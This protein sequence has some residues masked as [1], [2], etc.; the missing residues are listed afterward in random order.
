M[1]CKQVYLKLGKIRNRYTHQLNYELTFDE[2]FEFVK[3]MNKAGF[4]FSDATIHENKVL[5][6]KWYEVEGLVD[7]ILGQ[8]SLKLVAYLNELGVY[9]PF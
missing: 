6:K 1:K 3:E 2:A 7:Q 5:S 4:Q 9:I 8:L